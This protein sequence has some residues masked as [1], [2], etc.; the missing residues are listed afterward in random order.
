MNLGASA[1]RYCLKDVTCGGETGFDSCKARVHASRNHTANAGDKSRFAA[2]RNDA[3]RGA[4]DIDNITFPAPR[5]DRI[6]MRIE[7]THGD[8]YACLQAHFVRPMLAQVSGDRVRGSVV[9]VEFVPNPV[10]KRIEMGEELL[11]WQTAPAWVPHPL[12]SHGTDTSWDQCRIGN[13]NQ[14]SR[15]HV[16][17][18]QCGGKTFP[19]LWIVAQPEEELREAPFV[20][21]GSPA[22]L[23][24]F[25]IFCMG[26][27]R[28]L[29]GFLESA[30]VAPEK[31]V[32]ERLQVRI[33]RDHARSCG[34]ER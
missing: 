11:R 12:V 24:R 20:R 25:D 14:S 3:G 1:S 21:V 33:N 18:L 23:D 28:N 32:I 10:E 16:A 8:R 13:A 31:I 6:P 19:L 26:Q 15:N 7:G 30:M 4:N 22:P 27:L 17:V 2:H 29:A 5:A 34:V 9:S